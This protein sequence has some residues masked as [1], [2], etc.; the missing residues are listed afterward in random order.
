MKSKI[1]ARCII[2][3]LPVFIAGC[4]TLNRDSKSMYLNQT[5]AG[6]SRMFISLEDKSGFDIDIKNGSKDTL[7]LER[8]GI[9]N[10]LI[11][12]GTVSATIAANGTAA[13]M[14]TKSRGIKVQVRVYNHKSKVIQRIELLK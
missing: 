5:I 9:D 1:V 3:L 12:G 14:N 6:N 11:T 13:L 7:V 4:G 8:S 2:L 10:L